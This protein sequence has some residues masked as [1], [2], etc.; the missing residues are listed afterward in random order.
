[1]KHII[2]ETVFE[3]KNDGH[4]IS[5]KSN[6]INED[7]TFEY[8][9]TKYSFIYPDSNLE[10]FYTFYFENKHTHWNIYLDG[11][12]TQSSFWGAGNCNSKN[13]N[14][15]DDTQRENNKSINGPTARRIRLNYTFV[16]ESLEKFFELHP[17]AKIVAG[18]AIGNEYH[19][20]K[21][22]WE[23]F[24]E[25]KTT[26]TLISK[27]EALNIDFINCVFIKKQMLNI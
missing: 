4:H 11:F 9:N 22:F 3:D 20:R 8:K 16:K 13:K 5:L 21:T 14:D 27:Y 6:N 19:K 7:I 25:I 10:T 26:K 23:H 24:G 12:Y 2:T 1:M 18:I 17:N 15:I